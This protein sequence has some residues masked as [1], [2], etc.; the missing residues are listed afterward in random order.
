MAHVVCDLYNCGSGCDFV[1]ER[2]RASSPPSFGHAL[3]RAVLPQ[4][5]PSARGISRITAGATDVL[6]LARMPSSAPAGMT[7]GTNGR[8][9]S[10]VGQRPRC[11]QARPPRLLEFRPSRRR[12]HLPHQ[13]DSPGNSPKRFP[14]ASRYADRGV[15]QLM[16]PESLPRP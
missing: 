6:E 8:L 16:T 9:Q 11:F 5:E 13:T 12:R 14:V 7:A 3:D 1:K 10:V 15:C 2:L 4:V